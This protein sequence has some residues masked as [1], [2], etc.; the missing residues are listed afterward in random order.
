MGKRFF[1]IGG[2]VLFGAMFVVGLI[3]LWGVPDRF[4]PPFPDRAAVGGALAM[5]GTLGC[6]VVAFLEASTQ[7]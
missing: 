6:F 7:D 3:I 5:F 2:A 4:N 1:E